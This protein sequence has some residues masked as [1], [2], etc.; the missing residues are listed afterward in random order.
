MQTLR[1][2]ENSLLLYCCANQFVGMEASPSESDP[3]SPRTAKIMAFMVEEMRKLQTRMENRFGELQRD[4]ERVSTR[5][6]EV[7]GRRDRRE[8][9]HHERDL[10]S[11]Q[12]S[13]GGREDNGMWRNRERRGPR[14]ERWQERENE[15]RNV[16]VKLPKFQG[17]SNPESYLE[18]EMKVDQVFNCHHLDEERK[19][20]LASLEFE[21]YAMVWWNQVQTDIMRLRRAPINT[22]YE[23]KRCM[24]ERFVPSFYARELHNKLQRLIQGFKSVEDYYQEMELAMMRADVQEDQEATMSRFLHGLNRDIQDVLELHTYNTMEELIHRAVKVEQQLKRRSTYKRASSSTSSTWK[25]KA[26]KEGVSKPKPQEEKHEFKGKTDSNPSSSK[27]SSIKCFKCLGKGHIASQCPNKKTMILLEN[28]GVESESSCSSSEA[29]SE[30]EGL[31]HVEAEEGDLLMVRRLMGSL[32]KELDD[33]QRENIFHT[34]CLVEGKVCS[35]IIDGGS[36]TNVVSARL[37]DKLNLKTTPHPKAYKLQWLSEE[38]EL[39]VDKQIL[40]SF[41]IGRYKDDVICDVVPMEASHVLLGR[42]WQFDRNVIHD[43]LCNTYSFVHLGQKVVLKPLSPR[44]VCEDQVKM[45]VKREKEREAESKQGE[46]GE[47]SM[48]VRKEKKKV[49]GKQAKNDKK[50]ERKESLFLEKKE[51]KRVLMARKS[52]YLCMPNPLCLSINDVGT[53]QA[54]EEL[55]L[56]FGDVFPK[57]IPHGLPPLRGI[58]H[59]IDL[60]PGA[61]LPN[62]PS[63]RTT[64]QETKEIQRQVEE[65][66]EKGWVKESLSPCASP[67]ILVPKKEGTWRMCTDCRAINNITIRYRHPIPRLDDLLDELHGSSYFSKIDL[68]SGYHQIRMREGDEWKTAFKTKFGLYEWLVMPFGLTNAPSTF[69]KKSI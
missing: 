59:Q 50:I 57:D 21:G 24:K 64:R 46:K 2:G 26:K 31:H 9:E 33:T 62:R 19:V 16:K 55:L 56:E 45:R 20:N 65:L 41:S 5:L 53:P 7:E 38:G 34:R 60:I 23:L 61:Q 68:K 42:P 52:L 47:K 32:C 10:Y 44:E 18:W 4:N 35:L 40:I 22:W 8:R 58:E 29:P 14:R 54:L 66:I 69:M 25:D 43:G 15:P 11:S 51:I 13:D 63:Y 67:V 37:V 1:S 36:C 12:G 48:S 3:A 27:S 49:S 39:V 28:G 17:L 30:E 6:E